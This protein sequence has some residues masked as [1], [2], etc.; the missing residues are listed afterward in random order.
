MGRTYRNTFPLSVASIEEAIRRVCGKTGMKVGCASREN[1]GRL[2]ITL[3][4]GHILETLGHP[5][6]LVT[7]ESR[8]EDFADSDFNRE[9]LEQ[10]SKKVSEQ[11]RVPVSGKDYIVDV[12]RKLK[13][14][15]EQK[16]PA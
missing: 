8:I 10:F 4:V 5:E 13:E 15:N 7:D 3:Y 9:E 2:D 6:A 16:N 11:L 14:I 1:I 12:A